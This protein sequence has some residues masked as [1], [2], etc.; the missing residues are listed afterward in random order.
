MARHVVAIASAA[1]CS[2]ALVASIAAALAQDRFPDGP[3]KPELMKVCSGCHDAEIVLATLKTPA[4][5]ADTLKGMAE[6]GAEATAEEWRLIEQ[7][8]DANVAMIQINKAT[9]D[10]LRITMDLT[11]DV[12]DALVKHRQSE[13]PFKSI[14]DVKQ[15]PGI[16]AAKVDAR[17]NRFTF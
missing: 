10:E 2:V 6:L 9:A 12:A 11:P 7:Y 1:I 3:G 5:W 14:D 13:G 8:I 16:D 15:V 17:K 4:E